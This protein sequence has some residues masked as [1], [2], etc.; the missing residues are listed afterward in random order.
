M[1]SGE[2]IVANLP[3]A[4]KEDKRAVDVRFLSLSQPISPSNWTHCVYDNSHPCA[5][6]LS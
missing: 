2:N 1:S 5:G 3:V 4:G 6:I